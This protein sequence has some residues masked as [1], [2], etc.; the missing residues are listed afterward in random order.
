MNS[1]S[2]SEVISRVEAFRKSIGVSVEDFATR[3][4][5]TPN[6][7]RNMIAEGSKPISKS[8]II[9]LLNHYP[10]LSAEWLFRGRYTE[11][12]ADHLAEPQVSA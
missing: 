3:I 9:S 5:I 2:E 6:T 4:G 11:D 7:Y 10:E 8:T 1:I 12:A